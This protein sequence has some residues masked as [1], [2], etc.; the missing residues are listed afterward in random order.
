MT[1]N[2]LIEAYIPL[3]NSIACKRKRIFSNISIQELKSAAYFGLVLAANR[4]DVTKGQFPSYARFVIEGAIIDYLRELGWRKRKAYPLESVFY[5]SQS[6]GVEHL[7]EI[8]LESV[9]ESAQNFLRMYY[10]EK[11]TLKQIADKM[12]I[13]ESRAS[14]ILKKYKQEIKNAFEKSHN[15]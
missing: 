4:Y 13:V 6:V 1:T 5:L 15:F 3:A 11:L 8:L 10:L 9:D 7:L 12:G 14:Q 2:E